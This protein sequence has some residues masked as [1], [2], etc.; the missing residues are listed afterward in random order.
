[1][2]VELPFSERLIIKMHLLMCKYCSRF[3]N[4]LLILRSAARFEDWSEEKLDQT[5]N[6]SKEA[7]EKIKKALR[8]LSP[9]TL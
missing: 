1:M 9:K 7:R 5:Q 2:D 3:R 8:E 6:L 4:H